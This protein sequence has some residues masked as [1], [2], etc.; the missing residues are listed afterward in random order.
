MGNAMDT[1]GDT[2]VYVAERRR[3]GVHGNAMD[4]GVQRSPGV[5]RWSAIALEMP[6]K[7]Q[8]YSESWK[9]Q[10][11][12]WKCHANAIALEM[13]WKCHRGLVEYSGLVDSG[14]HG[15]TMDYVAGAPS[16][17]STADTLMTWEMPWTQERRRVGY[18]HPAIVVDK[19]AVKEHAW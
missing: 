5:R 10:E 19:K 11:M 9:C 18:L 7:C 14:V 17:W 6:W 4:S 3:V 16:R 8:E 1:S 12:P 2:L 15:N 13:P